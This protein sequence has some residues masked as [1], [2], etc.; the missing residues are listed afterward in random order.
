MNPNN[1]GGFNKAAADDA[2][3]RIDAFFKAKL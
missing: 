1:K 3:T 2:W